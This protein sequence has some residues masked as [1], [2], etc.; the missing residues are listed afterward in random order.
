[1]TG[2][3]VESFEMHFL[4]RA[5]GREWAGICNATPVV[6][7]TGGVLFALVTIRD[8]TAQKKTEGAVRDAESRF[9]ALV[10]A[11]P[12]LVWG[13]D[14]KGRLTFRSAQWREFSGEF[15]S[16]RLDSGWMELVHPDDARA[17][18]DRWDEA[19][20][21]GHPF[22]MNLRL[23]RF[24]GSYRWMAARI[25]PQRDESG[26]TVQWF[27]TC[28][29]VQNLKDIE[30]ALRETNLALERSNDELQQ[31]AYSASHDL[32]EPLRTI[33]GFIDLLVRHYGEKLHGDALDYLA[34]IRSGADRMR[35][36][37]TGLLEYS[38]AASEP[39]S[40]APCDATVAFNWAVGNLRRTIEE[41]GATVSCGRLP[42]VAA[43]FGR[44]SQLLQNLISNGIKYRSE[45]SPEVKITAESDGDYWR[46]CV[47]DNGSG[48]PPEYHE[49]VFRVFKRLHG[50]EIP[51]TGIGL[52]LC[53]RI[54]ERHGGRMWVE[55]EPGR[56]SRFYFTLPRAETAAAVA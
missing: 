1:L 13:C 3:F 8:L 23:R 37:I 11:I 45:S 12:G 7:S 51:G 25:T 20:R 55:S 10:H 15:S 19:V 24:D 47:A 28:L 16:E 26:K 29:E 43:D 22:D 33:N 4:D 46:F 2:E 40:E 38:R 39:W 44:L 34:F 32:Q 56:G 48:I 42:V 21:T 35:E 52:A 6:D 36:M 14:E 18:A 5:T 50:R 17:A 41:A 27:S 49:R 53:R 9:G 31:F 54:V 30:E